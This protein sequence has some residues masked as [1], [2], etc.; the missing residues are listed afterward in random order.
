MLAVERRVQRGIRRRERR[1]QAVA[2]DLENAAV[3]CFDGAP[4]ERVVTRERVLHR[5]RMPLEELG[6]PFDVGEEESDG[7]G[8]KVAHAS[9]PVGRRRRPLLAGA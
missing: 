6:G 9:L 3:V 4:H 2:D 1:T 7:T 5:L 8:R